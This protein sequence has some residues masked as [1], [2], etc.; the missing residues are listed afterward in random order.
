MIVGQYNFVQT[1][2]ACPE[3]YDVYRDGK[4]IGYVRLRYGYLTADLN[5]VEVYRHR[6]N[7][8]EYK[9]C[10]D[11]NAERDIFLKYISRK[12]KFM[13]RRSADNGGT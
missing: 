5:N 12:L 10:F 4:K 6:F 9:G 8:D 7:D 2:E 11:T 13:E 1:C 3:Q